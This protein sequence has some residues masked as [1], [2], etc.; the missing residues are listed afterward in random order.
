MQNRLVRTDTDYE[1]AE[2]DRMGGDDGFTEWFL[3]WSQYLKGSA[4]GMA[5]QAGPQGSTFV[6]PDSLPA[7]TA[8][9]PLETSAHGNYY[10]GTANIG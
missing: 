3:S 5:V 2:L 9:S 4:T 10:A 7:D 1:Q 8:T 6:A